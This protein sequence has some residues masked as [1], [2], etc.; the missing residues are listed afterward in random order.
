MGFQDDCSIFIANMTKQERIKALA[1]LGLFMQDQANAAIEAAFHKAFIENP[2]FTVPNIQ[3]AWQ[4]IAQ[5]LQEGSLTDWLSELADVPQ[6]QLT[7]GLVP[8]GN[9]PL[10]VFHDWLAVLASGHKLSLKKSTKDSVLIQLLSDELCRIE[11]RFATQ[12]EFVSLL[13]NLDAVIATGSDNSAQYFEQYFGKYPHIIRRNRTSV[14]ILDG[15]ESDDE[16]VALADDVLSYFGL[17]CRNVSKLL[18]PAG[19]DFK[20][21]LDLWQ[22][23]ASQFLAHNKYANNYD[24]NRALLLLNREAFFDGV[25]IMLKPS[26]EWAA[27]TSVLLY[28]LYESNAHCDELLAS[29]L[30]DIQVIIGKNHLPFGKAQ[31]PGLKDYADGVNTLSFLA[32]TEQHLVQKQV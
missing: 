3:R 6:R 11:P 10:V 9:I 7:V 20:K 25:F 18:L 2:W 32:Q 8:A 23:L 12:I 27:P 4:N 26:V 29:H 16:L 5:Q 28:E 30:S 24:Y 14:A 19:Y 22:P 21:L 17:G 31:Q 1:S 13:R 15:S